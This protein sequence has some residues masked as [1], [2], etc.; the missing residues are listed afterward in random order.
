MNTDINTWK[1]ISDDELYNNFCKSRFINRFTKKYGVISEDK[2]KYNNKMH[3]CYR[4][5]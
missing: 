1:N 3:T 4:K 2:K 5:K